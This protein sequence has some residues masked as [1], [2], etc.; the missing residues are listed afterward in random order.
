MEAFYKIGY[1]VLM[2]L[3]IFHMFRRGGCCGHGHHSHSHNNDNGHKSSSG[4]NKGS[5]LTEE[6]KKNAIDL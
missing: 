4:Q 6:E 5:F 2:V 1:L 3:L